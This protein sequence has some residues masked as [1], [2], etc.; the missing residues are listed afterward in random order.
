M[1]GVKKMD[2][3]FF[4]PFYPQILKPQRHLKN[5]MDNRARRDMRMNYCT[6]CIV[7]NLPLQDMVTWKFCEGNLS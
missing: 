2:R 5:L 7:E 4:F 6:Q 3:E 1:N